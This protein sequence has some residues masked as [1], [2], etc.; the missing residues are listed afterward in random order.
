MENLINN[1][2]NLYYK[3]IIVAD[4]RTDEIGV[5]EAP[6]IIVKKVIEGIEEPY[7]VEWS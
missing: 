2:S 6:K 3:Y 7:A 4:N 1:F 5:G